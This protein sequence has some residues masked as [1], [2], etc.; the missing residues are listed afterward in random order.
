MANVSAAGPQYWLPS[1]TLLRIWPI[2]PKASWMLF[3]AMSV[4]ATE[5][6]P[7]LLWLMFTLMS[8]FATMPVFW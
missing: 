3:A 4:L 7:T 1:I 2:A 5:E 6:A 8:P